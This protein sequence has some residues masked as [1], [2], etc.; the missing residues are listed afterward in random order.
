MS[1]D[2]LAIVIVLVLFALPFVGRL[3]LQLAILDED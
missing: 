1:F 3:Y 2:I